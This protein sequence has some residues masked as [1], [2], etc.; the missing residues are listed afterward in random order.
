MTATDAGPARVKTTIVLD[1]VEYAGLREACDALA[2][3]LGR[4]RVAGADVVRALLAQLR[5]DATQL[6]RVAEFLGARHA[7]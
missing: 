3:R 1:Q 2:A 5:T 4:P 7:A 6:D